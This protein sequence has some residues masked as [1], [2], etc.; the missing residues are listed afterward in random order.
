[1]TYCFDRLIFEPWKLCTG[2]E[3]YMVCPSRFVAY[4]D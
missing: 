4:L 2:D 3:V 1:M